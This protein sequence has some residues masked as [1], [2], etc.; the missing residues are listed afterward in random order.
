MCTTTRNPWFG[1][2]LTLRR[3]LEEKHTA[4]MGHMANRLFAVCLEPNTR[5]SFS[6]FCLIKEN[7]KLLS[8]LLLYKEMN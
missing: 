4:K 1:V 8:N 6:K 7:I 2:C 5:Q 3:V